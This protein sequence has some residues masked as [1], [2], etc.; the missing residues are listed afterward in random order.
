[1][2]RIV[3]TQLWV[4]DDLVG[5]MSPLVQDSRALDTG[6]PESSCCGEVDASRFVVTV[7]HSLLDWPEREIQGVALE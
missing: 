3:S 7:C 4:Y 1:M 6:A 5:P 2:A